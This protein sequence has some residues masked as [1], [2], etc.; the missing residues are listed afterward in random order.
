MDGGEEQMMKQTPTPLPA[1]FETSREAFLASLIGKNRSEATLRAYSADI[2]QFV[3]FLTENNVCIVSPAD[4]TRDDVT[5]YLTQL[6]KRGLSGV[7]R[8]RKLAALREYFRFLLAR[9]ALTTSPLE[10]IDTPKKERTNRTVLRAEE[11]HK[12]LSLAGGN[13]RDFAIFQVFLQAGLRVSELCAL[14]IADIDLKAGTLLVREGK[15]QAAREI[16]LE[17]KATQAIKSYL[18]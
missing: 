7:T 16:P 5:E 18:A 1:A 12:L 2:G 11:Y 3:Q 14:A 8:A 9:G 15:G 17:K 6:G 13:A 10:H 4:V